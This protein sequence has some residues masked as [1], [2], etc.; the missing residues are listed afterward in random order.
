[1]ER[2]R[3]IHGCL[4]VKSHKYTEEEVSEHNTK[5]DCWIIINNMVYDVTNFLDIHPGGK[6]MIMMVAGKDATEYFE[7]LHNK[8]ILDEVGKEYMIGELEC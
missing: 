1:M 8:N 3:H 5:G 4:E 2:L 6:S 7:E